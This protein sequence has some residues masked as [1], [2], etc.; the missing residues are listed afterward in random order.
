MRFPETNRED[1]AD[2]NGLSGCEE[3]KE[4]SGNFQN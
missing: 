2:C 4:F 3:L 1:E